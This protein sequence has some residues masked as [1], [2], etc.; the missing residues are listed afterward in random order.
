MAP[1]EENPET[2]ASM[3]AEQSPGFLIPEGVIR[4]SAG[5]R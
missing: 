2:R 3:S 1:P 5:L 4:Q